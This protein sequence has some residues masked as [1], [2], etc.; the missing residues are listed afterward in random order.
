MQIFTG[1]AGFQGDVTTRTT[2]RDI[3]RYHM[4]AMIFTFWGKTLQGSGGKGT[5]VISSDSHGARGFVSFASVSG[6]P[7]SCGEE[8]PNDFQGPSL[9][10]LGSRVHSKG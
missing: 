2:V 1:R 8:L 7:R 6:K 9:G 5:A 10:L 3:T 4:T